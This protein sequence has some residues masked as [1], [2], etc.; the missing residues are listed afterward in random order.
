MEHYQMST[1]V[2]M[3][4]VTSLTS[5]EMGCESLGEKGKKKHIII[6]LY[7]VKPSGCVTSK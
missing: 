1:V 4:D 6:V 7:D 5:L 3:A 2:K